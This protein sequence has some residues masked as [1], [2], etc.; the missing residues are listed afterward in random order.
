MKKIYVCLV[1]LL[2]AG[3]LVAQKNSPVLNGKKNPFIQEKAPKGNFSQ[4]KG[5]TLWQNDFSNQADWTTANFP[6]GTPPHTAGDWS[7]TTNLNAAPVAALKPAGFTTASTGYAI[8]NSDVEGGNAT[9]NAS[10]YYTGLIDLSA[11][12]PNGAQPFVVISFEQTHRRFAEST[13]VIYSLDGGTTWQE[14]EVNTDMATNT[15]T[16]NPDQLQVNLSSQIGNQASVKIGFKYVGQWDWFWAVDD[17]KLST[18]DDYDLEMTNVYWGSTGFWGARLPYYQIP[19]AQ[20]AP[21]DFGGIVSNLGA[22]NQNDVVFTAALASGAYTGSSAA[23]TVLAGTFDTLDVTTPLTPPASAANHIVNVNVSNTS[24]YGK[25]TYGHIE[26]ADENY[27]SGDSVAVTNAS[28]SGSGL[29]LNI[30]ASPILVDT[31][32]SISAGEGYVTSAGVS[33]TTSGTGTGLTVDFSATPLN[34]VATGSLVNTGIGYIDSIGAA[35]SYI[36]SGTGLTLDL[37]ASALGQVVLGT[38]TDPGTSYIDSIGAATTSNG[39]GNDLTVNIVT[40]GGAITSFT[41]NNPGSGYGLGDIITIAGGGATFEVDSITGGIIT[42]ATINAAGS[43]YS[44]GNIVAIDGGSATYSVDSV[45]AGGIVTSVAINTPGLGY[46]INDVLTINS[47]NQEAQVVVT[48]ISGGDITNANIADGGVGYSIGDVLII[49]GGNAT[50]VV[51]STIDDANSLDNSITNIATISVNNFIYARDNGTMSSG[52]FNAGQGFEVG[53]IFDMVTG[54]DLNGVDVVINPQAVAGAQM[55]VKLYSIDAATGDFLYVD[56]SEPFTLTTAN[57]G[58]KVTLTL[59]NGAAT[60]NADESYLVV[61][62]SLGDG[63]L[64]DDLIVG[65]AGLSEAQ[66][67]FYLDETGTWFYTTSTPMVRMNFDPVASINEVENTFG[68]SVY[69][70]PASDVINISLNKTTNASISV[71]DIT[72]KVVKTLSL[73]GLTTSVNTSNLMSGVYY[74]TITDGTSVATE[75]VIIKK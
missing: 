5:V 52:S 18:P 4:T 49:D 58:Q 3:T 57:L 14:V 59:I 15:N 60:L 19:I 40:S 30:T 9:Q 50:Y 6:L 8:I 12:G 28:G 37:A 38:I 29:L 42:S 33:T 31:I 36:G 75:K 64:S 73:N 62:G 22:S 65:T 2:A 68:F 63:G 13:F 71:I 55:F 54:A 44:V 45:V 25:I 72:G 32:S 56:E 26:N 69:P 67:S 61:A 34:Q 46:Q 35:T 20:I 23:S 53:N 16:T 1:G 70:N 47:G 27:V 11:T 48:G 10:I 39:S 51:D 41:I 66:T 74:V 7:I 24:L 17:V 43:G 21:I